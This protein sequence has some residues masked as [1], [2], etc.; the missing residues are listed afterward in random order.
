MAAPADF[1]GLLQNCGFSAAARAVLTDADR[2]NMTLANINA[3]TNEDV[4]QMAIT[5]R[6]VLVVP[7]GG[8]DARPLY[9]KANACGT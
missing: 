9:V 4:D 1:N 3:W 7:V 5:L 6:K 2:E 8:G